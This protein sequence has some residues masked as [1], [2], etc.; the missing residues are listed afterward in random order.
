[1]SQE[2]ESTTNI[3]RAEVSDSE[4]YLA[5]QGLSESITDTSDFNYEDENSYQN[6][7]SAVSSV[8]AQQASFRQQ[9]MIEADMELEQA[10]SLA[11]EEQTYNQRFFID[12]KFNEL[13]QGFQGALEQTTTLFRRED[14]PAVSAD[15]L[16]H[17]LEHTLDGE[18]QQGRAHDNTLSI[19]EF[20]TVLADTFNIP[21]GDFSPEQEQQLVL[22]LQAMQAMANSYMQDSLNKFDNAIDKDS[23]A[24]GAFNWW[25]K[26][27]GD[28][29]TLKEVA[30]DK[31]SSWFTRGAM[32]LARGV[33]KSATFAAGFILPIDLERRPNK[34]FPMGWVKMPGAIEII[35]HRKEI[36]AQLT[37][38]DT[39][40]DSYRRMKMLYHERGVQGALFEGA[41][42][43]GEI[44]G[45][46]G[47][48]KG[49]KIGVDASRRARGLAIKPTSR[50]DKFGGM[51]RNTERAFLKP[52]TATAKLGGKIAAI[53]LIRLYNMLPD[54]IITKLAKSESGV[55]VRKLIDEGA[56]P[57]VLQ[58]AFMTGPLK[59]LHYVPFK[60]QIAMLAVR[61][62]KKL[63]KRED[64][65]KTSS[66]TPNTPSSRSN[67][68]SKDKEK[69]GA[70][71]LGNRLALAY[72]LDK[73]SVDQQEM[74]SQVLSRIDNSDSETAMNLRKII[75]TY[76][77]IRSLS[78][79]HLTYNGFVAGVG[80][81]PS[82]VLF[83]IESG[84]MYPVN[85]ISLGVT[86][87]E[88]F[89]MEIGIDNLQGMQVLSCFTEGYSGIG[90]IEDLQKS[91]QKI[92]NDSLGKF[93]Q[94]LRPNVSQR[95]LNR[96]ESMAC[97]N[98]AQNLRETGL[99]FDKYLESKGVLKENGT[100]DYGK[101][102]TLRGSIWADIMSSNSG[103][104]L[105][106]SEPTPNE[107]S[108]Q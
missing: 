38:T 65:Y 39:Y 82:E 67:P 62:V 58:E 48:L 25:S 29:R 104:S 12:K 34:K 102:E 19:E 53:P 44:L 81:P 71:Y 76:A 14:G 93:F 51:L 24:A 88:Y 59:A 75:Q 91:L 31:D 77:P 36:I 46:A 28:K 73:L 92:K 1:M 86:D 32:G 70:A 97:Q 90:G 108:S 57:K 69:G 18:L 9:E 94:V 37:N 101:L 63:K 87:K 27:F 30:L 52:L 55:V 41:T 56:T 78:I 43:L 49:T 66:G 4:C 80:N 20:E 72:Q 95:L 105:R 3:S 10:L 40:I 15:R 64:A 22:L 50:I 6:C 17:N 96:T 42:I 11:L 84:Q 61:R 79:R 23:W 98:F 54:G 45:P 26:K 85:A 100:I 7:E 103:A 60:R 74:F 13:D 33:E 2:N 5:L 16:W 35:Q 99:T 89:A 107:A 83:D 106:P 68:S 8:I 47:A 21:K